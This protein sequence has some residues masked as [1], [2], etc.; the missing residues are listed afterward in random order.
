MISR[1]NRGIP[2]QKTERTKPK[3]PSIETELKT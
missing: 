2:T 1:N 3:D